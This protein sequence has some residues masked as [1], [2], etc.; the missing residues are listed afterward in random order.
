MAKA[1]IVYNTQDELNS[2]TRAFADVDPSRYEFVFYKDMQGRTIDSIFVYI[3]PNGF[4]SFQKKQD[5]E[6]N[7]AMYTMISRATKYALIYN[8]QRP[9]GSYPFGDNKFISSITST[10]EESKKSIKNNYN[11][12]SDDLIFE[13]QVLSGAASK[14][15]TRTKEE[16]AEEKLVNNPEEET[17]LDE[18]REEVEEAQSDSNKDFEDV[19]DD[20]SLIPE[21]DLLDEEQDDNCI[22]SINVEKHWD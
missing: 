6:F 16:K 9:D 19:L 12:Y 5:S 2:L 1:T 8:A 10:A 20:G 11:V 17:E 15:A 4:A 18:A 14:K 7:T 13:K 22:V 21:E 3:T